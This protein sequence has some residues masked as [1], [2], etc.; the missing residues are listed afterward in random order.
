MGWIRAAGWFDQLGLS[1]LAC[2]RNAVYSLDVFE[3]KQSGFASYHVP[4]DD[5][6]SGMNPNQSNY[7]LPGGLP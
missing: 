7:Y 6:A 5:S 3:T 1:G 4:G 2:K